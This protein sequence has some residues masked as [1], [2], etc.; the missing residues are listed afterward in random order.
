LHN[1]LPSRPT[2]EHN[3]QIVAL[4]VKLAGGLVERPE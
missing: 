4:A 1:F 3:R 2:E